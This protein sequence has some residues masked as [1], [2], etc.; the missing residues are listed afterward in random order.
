MAR[1]MKW[2]GSGAVAFACAAP[3]KSR[4]PE[5]AH[6]LPR[7][8]QKS[9]AKVKDLLELRA[10]LVGRV[11]PPRPS[12]CYSGHGSWPASCRKIKASSELRSWLNSL[13][14]AERGLHAQGRC[15]AGPQRTTG[16]GAR[17]DGRQRVERCVHS[18]RDEERFS[19]LLCRHPLDAARR[20][21]S[22]ANFDQ[23][24][25]QR[26]GVARTCGWRGLADEHTGLCTHAH[27][28]K[29]VRSARRRCGRH[30]STGD[31]RQEL[32]REVKAV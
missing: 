17:C 8:A 23:S 26:R 6:P 30:R 25:T 1:A 2:I 27:R 18:S 9:T 32:M 11:A 3:A 14:S 29:H 13:D 21:G 5:V 4:L 15:R 10:L 16:R 20:S 28:T 19:A 22:R 7:T 12:K 31:L 24:G